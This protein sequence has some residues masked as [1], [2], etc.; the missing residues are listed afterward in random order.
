MRDDFADRNN[1]RKLQ[2]VRLRKANPDVPPK[3][4]R[5]HRSRPLKR[6]RTEM[7]RL[8]SVLAGVLIFAL[9][10]WALDSNWFNTWFSKAPINL[11]SQPPELILDSDLE[12]VLGTIVRGD[13]L[14]IFHKVKLGET[15]GSI[16]SSYGLSLDEASQ[17]EQELKRL[18]AEK[19]IRQTIDTGQQLVFYFTPEGALS[20]IGSAIKK[21]TTLTISKKS[22]GSFSGVVT[23][24][25]KTSAERV[26]V[27]KIENSF[28]ESARGAGAPFDAIDELVDLFSD[29]FSFHRDFRQG[30][31]FSVIY[32]DTILED[33]TSLGEGTI[34]AAA[35]EVNGKTYFAVRFVGSDGVERYFGQQGELLGNAFLRYPLRFSRISSYFSKSRFHPKLKVRRPHNGVDFAAP[36]G[37]PIRSVADGRVTFAGRKGGSGIMVKI[38]HSDR[39]SSAYAHLSKIAKGVKKGSKVTRGQ[40]I[41]AVG[42][43]GLAT[44]PHLHY[45][46]YD[47]G[48]YVD[49]LK[50]KLP[51]VQRLKEGQKIDRVY[52]KRVLYTLLHYQSIDLEEFYRMLKI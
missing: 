44:G 29:Q 13:Q 18:G 52:L 32:Q 23:V 37:T 3:I 1:L 15:W 10:W 45:A 21:D 43:T 16:F 7:P 47:R 4:V 14:R 8:I 11:T 26:I 19:G 22:D 2:N 30:D 42:M 28:S 50:I 31:R 24:L 20:S 5:R 40:V 35:L 49:P 34:L 38:K 39:Y 12:P 9:A 6:K 51:R 33:G 25:P 46:F 17:V 41:G 36:T 48:K 27:G